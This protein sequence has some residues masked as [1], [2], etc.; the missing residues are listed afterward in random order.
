M[1][2]PWARRDGDAVG[3]RQE[4]AHAKAESHEMDADLERATGLAADEGE[5]H[6][7]L[8]LHA[9]QMGTWEIELATQLVRRAASTDRIFGLPPT[10]GPRQA[11]DYFRRVHPD[12]IARVT[13][14]IRRTVEAGAEH[15]VEYRVIW[16]DG[17]VRWLASRGELVRDEDGRPLRLI[18]ALVDLTDRR[19]AEAER[20]GL[21]ER[22]RAARAEADEALALLDTLLTT[23]PVGLCFLSP[24]YRY[25]RINEALAAMNGLPAAAHLGRTV[26]EVLPALATAV[27]PIF[28]QVLA[29]GEPLADVEIVEER[30]GGGR[31]IWQASY[32]PVRLPGG[33]VAGLGIVA[34][35]ITAYREAADALRLSEERFRV[36]LQNSPIFVYT[37]DRELRY[38]WAYN[39]G[40]AFARGP[41]IGRRDE[42]LLPPDEAAKLT[43]VKRRVLERERGERAEVQL[44]AD[45]AAHIYDLTLE[46]LRDEAGAVA[47]LTVAVIDIT[48]IRATEA[49]LRESE[50]RLRAVTDL[51]PAFLF[52][53]G[54]D[55][56]NDFVSQSFYD[57][58]GASRGSGIG[59][60]W[61]GY[62]HPDDRGWVEAAWHGAVRS[63]EP[64]TGEYR[65]RRR[66]GAY[67]WF[68]VQSTP[69]R[70]GS[71]AVARWFG[72]CLDIDEAKRAGEER[73]ALLTSERA[74][75]AAAERTARRIAQL[76]AVT[77][78]L[79][80]ALTP[81]QVAEVIVARSVAALGA[82]SGMLHLRNDGASTFD[83]LHSVGVPA[84][85]AALWASAPPGRALPVGAVAES[86]EA[87]FFTSGEALAAAY[88][89]LGLGPAERAFG[90]LAIVPLCVKDQVS[91]V[92]SLSFAEPQ[93]FTDEDRDVL[94]AMAGQGAQAIERARLYA[95]AQ[96]AVEARD[97]FIA[98]ASHDL[99]A[100]LTAL[101]G[102]AQLL[103]RRA[104]QGGDLERLARSARTVAEQAQRLNRMLGAM[105]DLSRIQSG[106]L[107]VDRLPLDLAE[108]AAAVVADMQPTLSKHRLELTGG[109][110][111]VWVA[112][113]EVRLG[114]VLYNLIGNG[115][116]Y[117]PGGGR[118]VVRVER[119]GDEACVA[120]AD[121]GIGIPAEALPQLFERFFR[122][123]NAEAHRIGG[124]GIGLYAVREIVALHGGTVDVASTEGEGST[125][126]VCLPILRRG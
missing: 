24:E 9:A 58:T 122:A 20:E 28:A 64:F 68:R 29:T 88:P 95:A 1:Y 10:E 77:A 108:L 118:V 4:R 83:L 45:G 55:G 31:R 36:A 76:Q 72:A 90:A 65:F 38:T 12:D 40:P 110:A 105:L 6:L 34:N 126:T 3:H 51:A 96:A 82:A 26:R 14:S 48:S 114:Q 119:R 109:A 66:D 89:A 98:I 84:A 91:G 124:L 30:P 79:A 13:D 86:G 23:A 62:L 70:D 54:P 35:D 103:E 37:T 100:P 42:E 22:E 8:A 81:E 71:G 16:D 111:G 80:E 74:A 50:A 93:L 43:A 69:F 99:R 53:T 21:L 106:Q 17:S 11:D 33:R 52:T 123:A 27:E 121:E 94:L 57:Y 46:P 116:K 102:Q 75:R 112:G 107:T 15:A 85:A 104:A 113:D 60:G 125:F 117:S 39:S 25:L 47:G 5:G 61:A 19:R 101:L 2:L 92:L 41:L 7:S 73:E 67:R 63:G 56:Q 115:V 97:S 49:A 87:E 120:V 78:A 32:Y 59:A 44:L 18:G